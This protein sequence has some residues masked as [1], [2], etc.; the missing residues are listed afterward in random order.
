MW[1]YLIWFL[2]IFLI[3][4]FVL[5]VFNYLVTRNY[6]IYN[7]L[8]NYKKDRDIFFNENVENLTKDEP[9]WKINVSK[10]EADSK[11]ARDYL[12]EIGVRDHWYKFGNFGGFGG[13]SKA[14]LLENLG[15]FPDVNTLSEEQALSFIKDLFFR[16]QKLIDEGIHLYKKRSIRRFSPTYWINKNS[17]NE[18]NNNK[19]ISD[20]IKKKSSIVTFIFSFLLSLVINII[21]NILTNMIMTMFGI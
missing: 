2:V 6:Y 9:K 18:N 13:F 10:F 20:S 14:S 15:T 7:F 19:M 4:F 16:G 11:E 1:N 21:G 12:K 17:E 3:I 5:T 8:I